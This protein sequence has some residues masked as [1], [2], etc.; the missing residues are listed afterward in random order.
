MPIAE[1][2]IDRSF[3]AN[4]EEDHSDQAMIKTILNMAKIFKLKV[5]AEG[6]ETKEQLAFLHENSCHIFQGYYFSKPL[7]YEKFE[8][9]YKETL[10]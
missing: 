9:Y 6:V 1:L 5:V 8:N 2:K 7:T 3:I 4:L 10:K